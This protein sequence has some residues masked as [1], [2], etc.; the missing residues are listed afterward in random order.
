MKKSVTVVLTNILLATLFTAA[1]AAQATTARAVHDCTVPEY[2]NFS[3]LA[4][5]E[6]ENVDYRRIKRT[7]AGATVAHIA[8][9]GGSIEAPTTQLADYAA[10]ATNAFYSFEGIKSSG[11]SKLHITSTAFDEPRGVGVVTNSDHTVSWHGTSGTTATT[12]VGGRDTAA[13][14]R[15]RAEL[16]AEGFHV[17]EPVPPD[18]N[19]NSTANIVNRNS[20]GMGVQLEI[21][22]AQ[23]EAFFSGGTLTR[24]WI[25]DPANRTLDFYRYVTAVN[26]ALL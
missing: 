5:C 11:N 16:I 15:V 22:R 4:G 25:E 7:P 26:R 8:I 3:E 20:R 19:G 21:T 12:Y 1:P 17:T 14:A 9:H 6:T 18:L 2:S 10:G 13:I 23:R 24:S